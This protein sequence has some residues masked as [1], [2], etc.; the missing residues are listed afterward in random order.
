MRIL[1]KPTNPIGKFKRIQKGEKLRNT[2]VL[3]ILKISQKFI[4]FDFKILTF[5]REEHP[6][7]NAICIN[8]IRLSSKKNIYFVR[9]LDQH[10]YY[11]KM[12]YSAF[13]KMVNLCEER[14]KKE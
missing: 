3:L 7:S 8:S 11:H 6:F 5:R 9:G 12:S 2:K 1:C 13:F 10:E 14:L 4:E